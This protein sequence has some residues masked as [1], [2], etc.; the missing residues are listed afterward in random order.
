[1]SETIKGRLK[2][3]KFKLSAIG[4]LPAEKLDVIECTSKKNQKEQGY[5]R[6]FK[7]YDPEVDDPSQ[8][9]NS[10]DFSAG[11]IYKAKKTKP[12]FNGLIYEPQGGLQSVHREIMQKYANSYNLPVLTYFHNKES[13]IKPV[14]NKSLNNQKV[15]E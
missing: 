9:I 15:K 3:L 2:V 4:V 1:M 11:F 5:H 10:T 13:I 12:L 8:I 14:E 6:V 7:P